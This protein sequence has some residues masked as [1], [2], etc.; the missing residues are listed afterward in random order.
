MTRRDASEN[1]EL[2][3]ELNAAVRRVFA[4][5][6]WVDAREVAI[7]AVALIVGYAEQLPPEKRFEIARMVAI[8]MLRLDIKGPA[9]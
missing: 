5:A 1:E 8:E 4:D 3:K 7:A 9:Q 6:G 2:A